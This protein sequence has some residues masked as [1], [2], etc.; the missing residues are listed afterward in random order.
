MLLFLTEIFNNMMMNIINRSLCSVLCL[1]KP[2]DEWV[3]LSSEEYFFFFDMQYVFV[4]QSEEI[5]LDMFEDE[6]REM[7]VCCL[8]FFI[9]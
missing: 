7:K 2:N 4:F 1:C 3:C 9:V 5:F 6:Y 8:F